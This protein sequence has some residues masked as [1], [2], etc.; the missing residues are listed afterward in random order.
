MNEHYRSLCRTIFI[1]VRNMHI[2]N[3]NVFFMILIFLIIGVPI[4]FKFLRSKS[5]IFMSVLIHYWVFMYALGS[6][7]RKFSINFRMNFCDVRSRIHFLWRCDGVHSRIH[8]LWRALTRFFCAFFNS[9]S[10]AMRVCFGRALT[11]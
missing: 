4:I 9:F 10:R 1:F 2:K 7:M 6:Y 8:S 11:H 5:I 3:K